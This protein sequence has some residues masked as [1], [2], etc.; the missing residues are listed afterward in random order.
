MILSGKYCEVLILGN[1]DIHASSLFLKF[2]GDVPA[3]AYQKAKG[4]GKIII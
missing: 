1:R 3:A 2:R 4:K